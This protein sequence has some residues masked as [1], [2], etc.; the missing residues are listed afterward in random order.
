LFNKVYIYW[1]DVLSPILKLLSVWK[2][3]RMAVVE[4]QA[5]RSFS[6]LFL[7]VWLFQCL[8]LI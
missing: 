7:V 3:G 8:T 2:T 6:K 4:G 5:E 1:I